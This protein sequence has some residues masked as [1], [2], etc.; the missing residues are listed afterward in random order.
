VARFFT[1][2][3][4][5]AP[6]RPSVSPW[7]T[8]MRKIQS[9]SVGDLL[10]N[11]CTRA[12]APCS[13]SNRVRCPVPSLPNA[14]VPL[15]SVQSRP[16]HNRRILITRT[17]E[18]SSALAAALMAYGASVEEIPTIRIEPLDSYAPLDEAFA[19]I[20]DYDMLILTS[21]IG[22]AT[23]HAIRAAG[24]RVDLEPLPAIAESVVRELAPN[25]QGKRILLARAEQARDL[26]PNALRSAG[27]VVDIVATYRT[28]LAEDSG[29]LL[30]AAFGLPI[31]A[32]AFTSSSTVHNFFT[33]L[34]P[35]AALRA[36]SGTVCC[37][38]GPVTSATL[39]SH[40]VHALV[41]ST[42]HDVPGLAATIA[43]Y[44]ART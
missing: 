35:E 13:P 3:P 38:I 42:Q 9:A 5:P 31:D 21:A 22:P 30:R 25:A 12:L 24:L 33:L 41:E 36:L 37:S 40:G 43:A 39:S 11:Y 16:L 23:A 15:E 18:Q 8:V 10:K 4:L 34:G 7:T 20:A 26:I 29:P 28:V 2:H 19:A 17:R 6:R 14:P 44:F 27:A 32:V 1:Q